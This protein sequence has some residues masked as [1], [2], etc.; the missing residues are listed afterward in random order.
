MT[1]YYWSSKNRVPGPDGVHGTLYGSAGNNITVRGNEIP[2]GLNTQKPS[3]NMAE[4]SIKVLRFYR[5]ACRLM[6]FILRIHNMNKIVTVFGA[7]RN[8]ADLIRE[9]NHYRDPAH[10]DNLVERAYEY[11]LEAEQHHCQHSY[12]Y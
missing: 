2:E 4:S 9:N 11:L 3:R 10:V 8:V 5:K 1:S 12:L 7:M 6:P